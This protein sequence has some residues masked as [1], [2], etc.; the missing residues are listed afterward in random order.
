MKHIGRKFEPFRIHNGPNSSSS[1]NPNMAMFI[2][3]TLSSA[4]KNAFRHPAL[5][6]LYLFHGGKPPE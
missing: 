1:V 6:P 5:R 3:L 4:N 2:I